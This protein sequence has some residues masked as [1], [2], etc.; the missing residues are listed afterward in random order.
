MKTIRHFFWVGTFLLFGA[1][2]CEAQ[3]FGNNF[4]RNTNNVYQPQARG[5]DGAWGYSHSGH[6]LGGLTGTVQYIYVYEQGE[7]AYAASEFMDFDKALALGR[8]MLA[9]TGKSEAQLSLGDVARALRAREDKLETRRQKLE[10][11]NKKAETRNWE[12]EKL[13]AGGASIASAQTERE[14]KKGHDVSC[15]YKGI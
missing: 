13:T 6:S 9:S 8:E 5:G 2:A 15:P 12:L 7:E 10:N 1:G 4:C 14:E 11:I 3:V